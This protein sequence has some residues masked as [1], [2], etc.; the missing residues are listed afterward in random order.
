MRKQRFVAIQKIASEKKMPP[1]DCASV[2]DPHTL[3]KMGTLGRCPP[4]R[5]SVSCSVITFATFTL[6][7]VPLMFF[8]LFLQFI[9]ITFSGGPVQ[10]ARSKSTLEGWDLGEY[11]KWRKKWHRRREPWSTSSYPPS[12]K[13]KHFVV[14]FTRLIKKL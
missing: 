8:C 9:F 14:L 2:G 11:Y 1:L 4:G 10:S 6:H 12:W 7:F 5:P 13:G 3:S